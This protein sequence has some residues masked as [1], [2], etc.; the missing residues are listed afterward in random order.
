M[1]KVTLAL[2]LLV[3]SAVGA[4]AA[5]MAVKA[6]AAALPVVYNWTGFYVGAN[7]GY[8]WQSDRTVSFA[9]NDPLTINLTCGG[10]AG[11]TCALPA[12][13]SSGGV[14]GGAQAGYNWKF[15]ST[16]V[17][18]I[19]AD[20]DAS[21]IKGNGINSNFLLAGNPSTFHETQQIDWF[22]T[23]RGRL[24]FL[25]TPSLLLFGTGG[26]AYGRLRESVGLNMP[27]GGQG[28]V[29]NG[30]GGPDFSYVCQPGQVNCF[31]G[32]SSRNA[33]GWTAGAG[34][35]YAFWKNVTVKAEYLYVNLGGGDAVKVTAVSPAPFN[36]L[37]PNFLGSFTASHNST[38]FQVVRLGVNVKLGNP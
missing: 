17:V 5:D 11:G 24:G 12:S 28:A 1:Q 15:N 31:A 34:F 23:V 38:D 21:G 30:L 19:E 16:W 14:L 4:S 6:P 3:I 26:F 27:G 10:A 36:F 13:Y 37:G 18:G 2:S 29:N 8:G 9:G 20:I 25:A 32:S 33:T 35:E 7:A 22:G